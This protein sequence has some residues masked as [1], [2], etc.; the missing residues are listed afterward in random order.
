[1]PRIQLYLR[2]P[3]FSVHPFA[4]CIAYEVEFSVYLHRSGVLKGFSFYSGA[5]LC[6]SIHSGRCFCSCAQMCCVK[7]MRCWDR[8]RISL[9]NRA[10]MLWCEWSIVQTRTGAIFHSDCRGRRGALLG[11]FVSGAVSA[12]W[13]NPKYLHSEL[14][15]NVL[16]ADADL[17]GMHRSDISLRVIGALFQCS[18]YFRNF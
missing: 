6:Y 1:M 4:R 18:E 11:V 17:T 2:H 14:H 10:E 12:V 13:K 7:R 16:V 5:D 15:F 8:G 3:P 9:L